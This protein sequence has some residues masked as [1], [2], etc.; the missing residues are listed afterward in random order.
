MISRRLTS[1]KGSFLALFIFAYAVISFFLAQVKLG[2]EDESSKESFQA[3]FLNNNTFQLRHPLGSIIDKE[4]REIIGDPQ[5]LLQFAIIGHGK[6]GTTSIQKWLSNHPEIHMPKDEILEL[7]MSEHPAPDFVL[8]LY[9]EFLSAGQNQKLGYKNPGEIRIPRSIRL[10]NKYFPETIL[11]VGIRHPVLWFESLFNFKVQNLPEI[12]APDHW[13]DPNQKIGAC[14]NPFEF[15]CVGTSKGLF[16]LHL[17][18]LGKTNQTKELEKQFE[19]RK[20]IVPTSNPVFL[21]DV[22]QLNDKNATRIEIFQRDLQSTLGL[23]QRFGKSPPHYSPGKVWG[24]ALQAKRDKFKIRIC[25]D[26]YSILRKA[27]MQI[28]VDASEFI[29]SSGF[30]DHP[31]VRVSSRE[32]LEDIL[33][34]RWTKDPCLTVETKAENHTV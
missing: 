18:F 12:F 17:A 2:H 11:F 23:E 16:H 32:Y 27:L 30:L 15:N 24:A 13:G 9:E 10:L 26:K 6:C 3:P 7:S 29:R 5:F 19:I 25:D 14:Q 20:K 4:R 33:K 34:N 31:D 21:F 28:A 8:R 22:D 1:R